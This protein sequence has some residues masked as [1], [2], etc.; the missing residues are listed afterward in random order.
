MKRAGLLVALLGAVAWA[1]P[2]VLKGVQYRAV[3]LAPDEKKSFKIPGVER[4]T[5]SSGDCLEESLDVEETETLIITAVCGGIRTSLVW[6][7]DGTRIH[8]MAC[9]EER[10]ARSDLKK[11]R[12][13]VQKKLKSKS[14]TACVRNGRVEMWG[15]TGDKAEKERIAELSQ[16]L[17]VEKVVDKVE[18]LEE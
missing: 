4:L 13:D 7:K 18:L 3:T 15:W 6:L 5:A 9:A 12:A 14:A 10:D 2:E 11:L 8:M 1:A 16:K 17:G